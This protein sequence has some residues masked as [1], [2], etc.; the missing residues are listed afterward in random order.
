[1]LPIVTLHNVTVNGVFEICQSSLVDEQ[2]Q[3]CFAV[4]GALPVGS[5]IRVADATTG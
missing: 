5:V 1:M 3:T 2:W 4:P